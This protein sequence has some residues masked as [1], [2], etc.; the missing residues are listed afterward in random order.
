METAQYSRIIIESLDGSL[1]TDKVYDLGNNVYTAKITIIDLDK[2]NNITYTQ[3]EITIKQ[4][5]DIIRE[6]LTREMFIQ[7]YFKGT[8]SIV[9]TNLPSQVYKCLDSLKVSK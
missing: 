3:N 8:N 9:F 1:R 5:N 7:M 4:A 6:H 2:P